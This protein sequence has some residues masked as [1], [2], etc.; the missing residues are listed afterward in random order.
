MFFQTAC[1]VSVKD[2]TKTSLA[3]RSLERPPAS[4]LVLEGAGWVSV[5]MGSITVPGFES[6]SRTGPSFGVCFMLGV[7]L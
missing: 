7:S 6:N 1:S 3:K 5:R 2:T 4:G